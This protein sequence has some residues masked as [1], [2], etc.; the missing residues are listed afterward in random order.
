MRSLTSSTLV[1]ATFLGI[2]GS[3][4]AADA[5]PK[6]LEAQMEKL[7]AAY[8]KDDVKAFFKDWASAAQP[9]TNEAT[10][11]ALYKNGSK[12]MFGE[13][14]PK[15]IKFRK[16][17]SVLDGDTLVVYFEAEFSKEKSGLVAVNFEKEKGDYKFIQVQIMKR[18]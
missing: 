13:Y 12:P 7:L 5:D 1:A 4:V 18:R 14:K 16:E 11:N 9:I 8:N 15:T 3:C 10:Y 6:K 2:L 17:G